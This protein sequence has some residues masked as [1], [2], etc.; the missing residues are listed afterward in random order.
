M[1]RLTSS[2]G[3]ISSRCTRWPIDR[4]AR[5]DI[6]ARLLQVSKASGAPTAIALP[7]GHDRHVILWSMPM[8]LVETNPVVGAFKP[9]RAPG[10]ERVLTDGTTQDLGGRRR[11]R[12]CA[13]SSAC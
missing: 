4:V 6:A 2:T 3:R 1:L 12:I 10:R 8:G 13:R 7:F 11:R 5:K 9:K